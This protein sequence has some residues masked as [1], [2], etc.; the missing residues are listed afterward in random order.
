MGP[1]SKE[2]RSPAVPKAG[3]A[4]L[5]RLLASAGETREPLESHPSTASDTTVFPAPGTPRIPL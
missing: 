3:A 1:G 2:L 4:A 5:L